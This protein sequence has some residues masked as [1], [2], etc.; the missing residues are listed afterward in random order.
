MPPQDA[1]PTP[2]FGGF[3]FKLGDFAQGGVSWWDASFKERVESKLRI[4]E[5]RDDALEL[6]SGIERDDKPW[7]WKDPA[8]CHF[9]PFWKEIWGEAAYII[10]VR[11]PYDTALSWQE[12]VI[13][14]KLSG[15]LSLI[16]GN[17]LRW[18]HMI[19]RILQHTD[20]EESKIV[21]GFEDLMREPRTS[22]EKL[23]D[24]LDRNCQTT[25]SDDRGVEGMAQAVNRRLW[26]HR[27]RIPFSQAREAS[28]GQK[29]LYRFLQGMVR[30]P[31]MKFDVTKYPMPPDWTDVVKNDERGGLVCLN[32]AAR[33]DKWN[34]AAVR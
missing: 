10:T 26:H 32:S 25:R 30:E 27:S 2:S 13:S 21:L 29:A 28:K 18:Q 16:E 24:F 1:N 15:S 20:D 12:F 33:F 7:V 5:Y 22:A 19:L 14:P 8:L 31:L 34:R 4:R 23:H 11:N 9:L 17:L 6:I 3:G